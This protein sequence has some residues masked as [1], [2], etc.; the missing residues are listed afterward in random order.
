MTFKPM[1]LSNDEFNLDDLDYTELFI[2]AKRDGVRAEV[3]RE[4]LLGRS[5]KRFPNVMLQTWFKEVCDK[6]PNGFILEAEIHSNILPCR[7][8]SGICNS[9][10]KEIP[11]DLK[12]Y[13]FGIYDPMETFLQRTIV[14]NAIANGLVSDKVHVISQMQVHSK[15]EVEAAYKTCL[16]HGF[17]GAVLMDG[18]KKYKC[19]RVTIKQHIGFKM[20]P[21]KEEDLLIIGVTERLEN[22]NESQ[23][24]ELNQSFKRNTVDSKRPT[25][26]AATFI[27]KL[28]NGEEC[29]VTITGTEE[30]RREI[31][32]NKMSY[33]GKYAV[34]K[35]MDYGTKDK[36]RHSRLIGIKEGCEK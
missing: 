36:L 35:S 13:M 29:G 22:L 34:V 14:L 28:P 25:G 9:K 5:L 19:G 7:T 11:A 1:L 15:Q 21:H 6:L 27:C 26:I 2:S 4:G 33:I 23:K 16:S 18:R 3:T 30:S 8:I 32:D 20:K 10:D 24:N 12:L 17:E 31:W